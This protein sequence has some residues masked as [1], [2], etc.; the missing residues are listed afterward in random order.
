M[1]DEGFDRRPVAQ[2]TGPRA[3]EDTHAAHRSYALKLSG[4]VVSVGA[5]ALLIGG[6]IRVVLLW[7]V[8]GWLISAVAYVTE[9]PSLFGKGRNGRLGAIPS[10]LLAPWILLNLL[11]LR[12]RPSSADHVAGTSL[13]LGRRT[14]QPPADLPADAQI[15]DLTCELPAAGWERC[16]RP[17]VNVPML[18]GVPP[19]RVDLAEAVAVLT[20]LESNG[21]VYLHCALGHGRT[22]NVAAAYL[23]A[24]FDLTP[25]EALDQVR[26]ARPALDV[27]PAQAEAVTDWLASREQSLSSVVGD[28]SRTE[29]AQQEA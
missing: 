12:T 28:E 19:S 22:G 13:Y 23:A 15:L 25:D 8:C 17:Y 7:L 16:R 21:A 14:S 27:S 26:A 1:S 29:A 3:A 9:R 4:L 20:G 24:R 5:L 11:I 6:L 18:D 10:T 2:G